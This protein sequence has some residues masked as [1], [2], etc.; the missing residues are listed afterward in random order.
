MTISIFLFQCVNFVTLEPLVFNHKDLF[1]TIQRF[2]KELSG[3]FE[4]DQVRVKNRRWLISNFRIKKVLEVI[5]SEMLIKSGFTSE[6]MFVWYHFKR[7][8]ERMIIHVIDF[9][10]KFQKLF[11]IVCNSCHLVLFC[12]LSVELFNFPYKRVDLKN[13]C[14]KFQVRILT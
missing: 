8:I 9:I 5:F 7:G 11:L 13:L 2:N 3:F 4:S 1:M 12:Q 10:K 6:K 14:L